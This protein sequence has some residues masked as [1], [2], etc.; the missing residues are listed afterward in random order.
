MMSNSLNEALEFFNEAKT[1]KLQLRAR[2]TFGGTNTSPF[3]L[4]CVGTVAKA[5]E[6]GDL[7]F[8]AEGF[9]L[10]IGLRGCEFSGPSRFEEIPGADATE[11]PDIEGIAQLSLRSGLLLNF[12]ILRR[13]N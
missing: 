2:L 10:I 9:T 1:E 5:E 6:A 3:L 13:P 7:V 8:L 4:T 11:A 12:D